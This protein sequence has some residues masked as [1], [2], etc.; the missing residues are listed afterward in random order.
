[1]QVC[2]QRI[3]NFIEYKEKDRYC[4]KKVT[5]NRATILKICQNLFKTWYY[6]HNNQSPCSVS[7]RVEER[8]QLLMTASSRGIDIEQLGDPTQSTSDIRKALVQKGQAEKDP[9]SLDPYSLEGCI[10]LDDALNLSVSQTTSDQKKHIK[11]L[12]AKIERTVQT[13]YRLNEAVSREIFWGKY[14]DGA[15][16]SEEN[17]AYNLLDSYC[18]AAHY[19]ETEYEP[20]NASTARHG[21]WRNPRLQKWASVIS[22]I[23]SATQSDPVESFL[24]LAKVVKYSMNPEKAITEAMQRLQ[25]DLSRMLPRNK[26]ETI[27]EMLDQDNLHRVLLVGKLPYNL[28]GLGVVT[29]EDYASQ[30][31]TQE[32]L[33]S[34]SSQILGKTFIDSYKLLANRLPD[35][36]SA[37]ELESERAKIQREISLNM[38]ATSGTLTL[39]EDGVDTEIAFTREDKELAQN[40]HKGLFYE[41]TLERL[42]E[43]GLISSEQREAALKSEDC[44][45][46][47]SDTLKKKIKED[48]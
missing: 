48:N 24:A 19:Y 23:W 44:E 16:L 15:T 26:K 10:E 40:L 41:K 5:R 31:S 3:N 39:R 8:L 35:T 6:D 47:D 43:M 29:A 14:S 12:L 18:E 21:M 32:A 28:K 17:L 22:A 30:L 9:Y 38:D 37:A 46:E 1:M 7:E 25:E 36:L 20:Y 45:E 42:E 34:S 13:E 4:E 11:E 2:E 27:L 33:S